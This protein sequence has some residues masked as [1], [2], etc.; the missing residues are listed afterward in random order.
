MKKKRIFYILLAILVLFLCISGFTMHPSFSAYDS[1]RSLA[2]KTKGYAVWR[3]EATTEDGFQAQVTFLDE[4]NNSLTCSAKAI[5]PIWIATSYSRTLVNCNPNLGNAFD[6][7][8][9]D[10]FGVEP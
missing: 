8:P 10:Y 1:C 3:Y 6:L 4:Y 9:E 2:M 5:G 7:C